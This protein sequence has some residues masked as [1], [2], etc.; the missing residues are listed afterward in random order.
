MKVGV[1]LGD[2]KGS[3]ETFQRFA[4]VA[5]QTV[6]EAVQESAERFRLELQDRIVNG[7]KSGIVYKRENPSRVHQAS[8]PYES[9]ADDTG[10]LADSFVIR[11]VAINQYAF[12]ADV[13]STAPYAYSLEFGDITTNL[14]PRPFFEPAKLILEEEYGGIVGR[15]WRHNMQ[16]YF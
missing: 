5:M 6:D 16:R 12:S 14:L 2:R 3:R 11:Y 10:Q 9:P 1:R 7:V 13:S 15:V 8:A 4:M